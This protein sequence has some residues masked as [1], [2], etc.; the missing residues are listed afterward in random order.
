MNGHGDWLVA[1]LSL[2]SAWLMS[3]HRRP[4]WVVAI[5]TNVAGAIY[6][7]R[8]DQGGLVV[9]EGVFV[10]INTRGWL[11]WQ[12]AEA[13]GPSTPDERLAALLDHHAPRRSAI[14]RAH[15]AIGARHASGPAREATTP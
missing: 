15:R 14:V 8:H 7:A 9:L 4:A 1:A 13:P 5:L 6:F 12:P 2:A 11:R 10:A 3:S